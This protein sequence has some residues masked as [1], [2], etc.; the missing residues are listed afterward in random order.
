[1]AG[2]VG[3]TNFP[4]YLDSSYSKRVRLTRD[5]RLRRVEREGARLRAVIRNEYSDAAV[6]RSID[7][8]VV[9]HGTLLAAELFHDP[10]AISRQFPAAD[11]SA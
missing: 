8:I 3:A 7:K 11:S 5:Y 10:A 9:E 4:V 2:F 6:E 1:M